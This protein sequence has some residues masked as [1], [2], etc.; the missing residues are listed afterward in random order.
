M[1]IEEFRVEC[2]SEADKVKSKHQVKLKC[3]QCG[4][5][6]CRPFAMLQVKNS[7]HFC[8]ILCANNS[9][10]HG[11]AIKSKQEETCLE[12]YGVKSSF[13][14]EDCKDKIR[15]TCLEKFGVEYAS[16]ADVIKDKVKKT[17]IERH[18]V[19][20]VMQMQSTKDAMMAGT[21]SK[22]GVQY[23]LQSKLGQEKMKQIFLERYGVENWSQTKEFA[24][25]SHEFVTKHKKG[26]VV[27]KGVSLR[28]RSS[29]EEQFLEACEL[30]KYVIAIEQDVRIEYY[31][32]GIKHYYF[33]D[34]LVKFVNDLNVLVEIKP[35][36]LIKYGTNP[37]KFV[38]ASK[39][40]KNNHI[41]RFAIITETH[42]KGDVIAYLNHRCQS[43]S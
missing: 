21:M 9:R 32:N 8:S 26:R 43:T 7:I 4:I 31:V 3:D 6:F 27:V 12:R 20:Y 14:S 11:G 30:S 40:V 5:E 38:A 36:K 39:Y 37:A 35:R 16:S 19:E 25:M 2:V 34:F 10:F 29:Y 15:K 42:L 17:M 18:G 24:V 1:Y 22:Y 41:N 33:A 23:I 13:Q 28:Y